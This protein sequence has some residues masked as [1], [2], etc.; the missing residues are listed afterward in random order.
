MIKAA[1]AASGTVC[2]VW[3]HSPQLGNPRAASPRYRAVG[4][5][6]TNVAGHGTDVDHESEESYC[7]GM[8]PSGD[9]P[10]MPFG[11]MEKLLRPVSGPQVFIVVCT[12]CE[13][14]Y[15]PFPNYTAAD[16]H[17]ME[18][19][20]HGHDCHATDTDHLTDRESDLDF[21]LPENHLP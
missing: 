13:R 14:Q 1:S 5:N 8:K 19:R 3:A 12:T 7:H 17:A 21:E 6:P 15:G 20:T 18:F 11:G 10:T 4:A 9:S 2:L 16:T